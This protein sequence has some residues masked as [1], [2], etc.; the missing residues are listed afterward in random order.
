MMNL[1]VVHDVTSIH[2][3]NYFS[4]QKNK[5]SSPHNIVFNVCTSLLETSQGHDENVHFILLLHIKQHILQK[6][7]VFFTKVLIDKII[8][9]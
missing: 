9:Y 4:D 1:M 6:N 5:N 3:G 8:K 2:N 7:A